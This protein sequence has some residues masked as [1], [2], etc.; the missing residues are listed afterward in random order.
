M[1]QDRTLPAPLKIAGLAALAAVGA[2]AGGLGARAVKA[3]G[4]PADDALNLLVAICLVG[5]GVVTLAALALR[6]RP[7]PKGCGPLQAA[8]TLLAGVM[9]AIP[10]YAT[11]WVSA[12][13]AF[14]AVVV[15]LALQSALN[16]MLWRRAD[17]MLRRVMVETGA[18]AFWALQLGLF[19]YAAAERL[20]LVEGVTAW[21]MISVLMA[22]YFVA[23]AVAAARRGIA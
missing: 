20:G 22:V 23:S 1:S 4:L 11:R 10:I 13:V 16:L 21:G 18:L 9:L 12:D 6:S 7:L 19:L 5:L 15:L 14:G 17:E 2:V 3:Q 8:V